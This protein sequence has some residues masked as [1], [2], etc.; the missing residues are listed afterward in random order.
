MH[1]DGT[2]HILS[3]LECIVV[4]LVVYQAGN[5]YEYVEN[6]MASSTHI[7]GM[8]F[9]TAFRDSC[10]IDDGTNHVDKASTRVSTDIQI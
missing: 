9:L 10:N 4:L 8:S 3:K 2:H 5:E 6:L 7:E 1:P